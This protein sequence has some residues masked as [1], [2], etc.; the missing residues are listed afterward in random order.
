MKRGFTLIEVLV[1]VAIFSTVMT[2]AL[3]ALLAMSEA[4]RRAEATKSVIDNLN[5]ALDSMSRA[6]RTGQNYHCSS[7]GTLTSPLDCVSGSSYLA[8]LSNDGLT[9]VAYCLAGGVVRRQLSQGSLDTSC[10]S[11]NFL[12][13]TAAEVSISNLTF[14]VV[15]SVP[16]SPDNTQPKVTILLNGT[17]QVT[18]SLQSKFDL[19]TSVTQRLYDQ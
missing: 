19:Q 12:P 14:Y 9:R 17:V 4:D 16:G 3:G 15:G 18:A 11:S 8:F 5:F 13:I 6:I 2:I 10:A 1:S 7:Q